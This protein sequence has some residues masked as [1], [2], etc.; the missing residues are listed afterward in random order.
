MRDTLRRSRAIRPALAPGSPT[1]SLGHCAR[2]L[3]TLAALL[4]GLVG[5][6]S[7]PLPHLATTGPEGPQPESRVKRC[8]R[9]GDNAPIL[10]AVS[11]LPSVE[12]WRRPRA[13]ATVGLVRAGR[14]VGRGGTALMLHVRLARACP[15]TGLAGASS[16]AGPLAGSAPQRHGRV[17]A[18]GE[19]GG[20]AGGLAGRRRGRRD[21][22]AR[23]AA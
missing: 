12:V 7:P 5:S 14:G 1:P 11:C 10:E 8:A 23:H 2:H 22:P 13:L 19:P 20:G 21:G 6:P 3:H 15:A 16:P 4:S 9:W 17:E 18:R